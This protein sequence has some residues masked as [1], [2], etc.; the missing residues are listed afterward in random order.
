MF[1]EYIAAALRWAEYK[2]IES[3]DPVFVSVPGLNG[4]WATGK[5]V[6]EA[7]AELIEVIEEWLVLGIK[8]GHTIPAIEGAM[9][10]VSRQKPASSA[11]NGVLR[12][13]VDYFSSSPV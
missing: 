10:N 1:A 7:R 5:T 12:H 8:L 11:C 6:E 9:I 4:A 3:D 2:I 13:K